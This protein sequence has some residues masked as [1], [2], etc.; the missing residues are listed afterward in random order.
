MQRLT[1][2]VPVLTLLTTAGCTVNATDALPEDG[3]L[4]E[5]TEAVVVLPEPAA[6]C[7]TVDPD[8]A[9]DPWLLP[10]P[11]EFH[12]TWTSPTSTYNHAGCGKY[13]IVDVWDYGAMRNA[14]DEYSFMFDAYRVTTV[15]KSFCPFVRKTVHV[16]RRYNQQWVHVGGRRDTGNW[17]IYPDGVGACILDGGIWLREQGGDIP[18]SNRGY[19]LVTSLEVVGITQRVKADIGKYPE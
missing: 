18:A 19:R 10:P 7:A 1:R 14:L 17:A 8:V 13:Y 11:E 12:D 3:P 9:V 6:A 4:A 16:Y 15:S 5:A 2:I